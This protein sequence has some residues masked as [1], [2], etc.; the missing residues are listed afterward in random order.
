MGPIPG[1]SAPAVAVQSV[2]LY[3]KATRPG[4]NL[5][6]LLFD[7]TGIDGRKKALETLDGG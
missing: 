7:D 2:E 1:K 6:K 3:A 4:S 5:R